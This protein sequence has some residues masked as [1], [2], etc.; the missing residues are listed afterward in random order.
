MWEVHYARNK[1]SSVIRHTKHEL[2]RLLFSLIFTVLSS[3]LPNGVICVFEKY[4]GSSFTPMFIAEHTNGNFP[5]VGPKD[6]SGVF[7]GFAI[8]QIL[9]ITQRLG[10]GDVDSELFSMVN[11]TTPYQIVRIKVKNLFKF[12]Q[13]QYQRLYV[14]VSRGTL[15]KTMELPSDNNNMHFMQNFH[16][17]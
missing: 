8:E 7:V 9:W 11:S 4:N 16:L 10:Y 13:E 6:G 14:V 12:S 3:D 2:T 17:P 5:K 1:N 15:T